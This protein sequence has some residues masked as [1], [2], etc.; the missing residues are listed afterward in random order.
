M[1]L[2]IIQLHNSVSY[3]NYLWIFF[4]F[5]M[6]LLYI[7]GRRIPIAL[8]KI[9]ALAPLAR[10]RNSFY[11]RAIL[12]ICLLLFAVF[13]LHLINS[14]KCW[15]IFN[16]WKFSFTDN[17]D[18]QVSVKIQQFLL[19]LFGYIYKGRGSDARV[20]KNSPRHPNFNLVNLFCM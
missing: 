14:R 6:W 5:F 17:S 3:F 1:C 15:T 13:Q 10:K 12:V 16:K 8:S 20:T 2:I 9:G 18:K 4:S 11:L 7:I 19:L